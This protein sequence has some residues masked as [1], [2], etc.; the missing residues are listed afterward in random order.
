MNSKKILYLNSTNGDNLIQ[1]GITSAG[2]QLDIARN[3]RDAQEQLYV[4]DYH[5]GLAFFQGIEETDWSMSETFF[6]TS[7][8]TEWVA[9][10]APETLQDNRFCKFLYENFYGYH[11]LP[12]E[13]N[14]LVVSLEHAYEMSMLG[15]PRVAATHEASQYGMIAR[16]SA[17]R[18]VFSAIDK[19]AAV[20]A[21]VL[22]SGESGSGKERIAR[23]IHQ[24]SQRANSHFIA[25]NCGALPSHLIQ[26]E[27]FGHEKGSFTGAH[28]RKVGRIEAATGGTLFLDEIG[29]LPLELQVNLLRF[30][31]EKTIERVGGT[32]SIDVDVRVI[33]ATHVDL[34]QA[35]GAGK[36]REDLYFRLNVLHLH[37]P[38]L[39]ERKGDIELLAHFFFHEF[40]NEKSKRVKGFSKDALRAM[41]QYHWPGN[42]REL[43]NRVRRAMVMCD[44]RLITREDLGLERRSSPRMLLTLEEARARAEQNAIKASLNHARNNISH[45]AR[46]LGV[47]RV[48]LYRLMKAY[49]IDSQWNH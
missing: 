42:V 39:V 49:G 47:S 48:T 2:W 33:A 27:L 43:M 37:A 38:A 18:T 40:A 35:V 6:S 32:E 16:S 10:T 4:N 44:S 8:P 31:Q 11:T 26:S 3:L 19:F 41:N 20:E 25:V 15:H 14:D 36:F 21:P 5:V 13:L 1:R 7:S 12:P 46:L 17:M 45:A 24:R 30:L 23:A 29:D 9:I 22:L 28:Q 34:E